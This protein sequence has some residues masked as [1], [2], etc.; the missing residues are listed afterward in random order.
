M[1]ARRTGSSRQT[2]N[3]SYR[4][5]GGNWP[6]SSACLSRSPRAVG[7][8]DLVELRCPK[9]VLYTPITYSTSA[10]AFRSEIY[11]VAGQGH[12]A[13]RLSLIRGAL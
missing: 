6:C 12:S 5:S 10:E 13:Q 7:S 2:F 9:G 11:V 8:L 4:R 3:P 1:I